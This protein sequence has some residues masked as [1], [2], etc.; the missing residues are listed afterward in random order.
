MSLATDSNN[1]V[2]GLAL[3]PMRTA[4]KDGTPVLL[5]MK[6]NLE[7]YGKSDPERWN[8]ILFVG[9]NRGNLMDWGFAAPVGHGGFPDEWF[10]GWY[11]LQDL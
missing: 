9:F 1:A 11:S 4:P 7:Q 3:N 8:G 10:E 2:E 5:K 6:S